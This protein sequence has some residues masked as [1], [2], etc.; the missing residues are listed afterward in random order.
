MNQDIVTRSN[1]SKMAAFNNKI[2]MDQL[3]ESPVVKAAYEGDLAAVQAYLNTGRSPDLKLMVRQMGSAMVPLIVFPAIA[4]RMEVLKCLL[5]WVSVDANPSRVSELSKNQALARAAAFGQIETTQ[6]LLQH[7]AGVNTTDHPSGSPPLRLALVD[8]HIGVARLL[9]EHHADIGPILVS[10][11][12]GFTNS[13]VNMLASNM[14]AGIKRLYDDAPYCKNIEAV[15]ET[16]IKKVT[17]ESN[18]IVPAGTLGSL[19]SFVKY[20]VFSAIIEMQFYCRTTSHLLDNIIQN[21]PTY[22]EQIEQYI[23]AMVPAA[24]NEKKK[25]EEQ[26]LQLTM[27]DALIRFEEQL[28][29][30]FAKKLIELT[31]EG[32][33]VSLKSLEETLKLS[34]YQPFVK[35]FVELTTGKRTI[36]LNLLKETLKLPSYHPVCRTGLS[37]FILTDKNKEELYKNLSRRITP[38]NMAEF[39]KI[40]S[41]EVLL[42]EIADRLVSG[43]EVREALLQRKKEIEQKQAEDKLKADCNYVETTV[44][45]LPSKLDKEYC[46]LEEHM[47]AFLKRRKEIQAHF[48]NGR[49]RAGWT[50]NVKTWEERIEAIQSEANKLFEDSVNKR[51]DFYDAY[52][53]AALEVETLVDECRLK[54]AQSILTMLNQYLTDLETVASQ[55]SGKERELEELWE[56]VTHQEI[57]YGHA[58]QAKEHSDQK[59]MQ[60]NFEALKVARERIVRL[61]D[62]LKKENEA[63]RKAVKDQFE[64]ERPKR[65]AAFL[66]KQK[67]EAA[68]KKQA[69]E[70]IAQTQ[71]GS[72]NDTSARVDAPPILTLARAACLNRKIVVAEAHLQENSLK[73]TLEALD[74]ASTNLIDILIGHFALL[75]SFARWLRANMLVQNNP[76]LSEDIAKPLADVIFHHDSHFLPPDPASNLQLRE[77]NLECFHIANSNTPISRENVHAT[78]FARM[79]SYR[80]PQRDK[81][82]LDEL[83]QYEGHLKTLSDY[84]GVYTTAPEILVLARGYLYARLGEM[85]SDLRRIAPREYG[86]REK[87]FNE[88]IEKGKHYRHDFSTPLPTATLTF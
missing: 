9:I 56:T 28:A 15:A 12:N 63:K 27:R 38:D 31:T 61:D 44:R 39:D 73:T 71:T 88:Y 68:A 19:P 57:K 11:K 18:F 75:G 78:L 48:S 45:F 80:I 24:I 84:S 13:N 23:S 79:L 5:E 25:S 22:R 58:K 76:V 36:G 33:T 34:S 2:F 30:L 7:G 85:A 62:E 35:K 50:T 42:S 16:L 1:P 21:F 66:E 47:S 43:E 49:V 81:S 60:A 17:A 77:L 29:C 32:G 74:Y 87:T 86:M 53:K 20:F 64:A 3:A 70:N 40:L 65:Q 59:K 8:G 14:L 69:E 6:L 41:T 83:A 82:I 52:Y 55:F 54:E 4:G 51:S 37:S 67:R 72:N 26:Q 46:N 10:V